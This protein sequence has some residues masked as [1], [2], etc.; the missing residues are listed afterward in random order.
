MNNSN[1]SNGFTL[2]IKR[3]FKASPHEVFDAWTKPEAICAWFAPSPD[4]TSEVDKLELTVGGK[5]QFKMIE[6]KGDTFIVAGEYIQISP[7]DE[8]IFTWAWIHGDDKSE[9]L[10]SLNFKETNGNTELTLLQERLPTQEIKDLH[11]EGWTAC[12]AR[13]TEFVEQ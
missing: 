12:L 13:L 7:P 8:L 2:E 11:N 9:M 5:Y 6:P 3:T 10:V 1:T 4:M